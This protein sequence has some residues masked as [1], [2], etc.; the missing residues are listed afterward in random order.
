MSAMILF[1]YIF[2]SGLI[3]TVAL[4]FIPIIHEIAYDT[5]LFDDVLPFSAQ[6]RD[7]AWTWSLIW[8]IGA[9]AGNTVWMLKA[10][11]REQAEVR[12]F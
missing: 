7:A 12:S 10:L 5:G 2:Q 3:V 1:Q 4:F 8:F 9:L 11:Q 6:M